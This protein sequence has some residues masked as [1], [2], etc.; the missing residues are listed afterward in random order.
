VWLRFSLEEISHLAV[1]MELSRC[2]GVAAFERHDLRLHQVDLVAAALLGR[3]RIVYTQHP[4]PSCKERNKSGRKL[5][6]SS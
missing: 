1:T 6:S 3:Y 4:S 2:L 5:R